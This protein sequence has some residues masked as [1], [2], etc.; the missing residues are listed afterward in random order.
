VKEYLA[1]LIQ[2]GLV[3]PPQAASGFSDGMKPVTALEVGG[4]VRFRATSHLREQDFDQKE[5][6][7]TVNY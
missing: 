2:N 3:G 5:A 6:G 7:W 1:A 4:V